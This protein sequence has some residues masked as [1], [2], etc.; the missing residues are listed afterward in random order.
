MLKILVYP[1]AQLAL[2]IR[3]VEGDVPAGAARGWVLAASLQVADTCCLT[4]GEV[5]LRMQDRTTSSQR[6]F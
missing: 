4:I 3:A 6:S 5:Q 1:Y 2:E